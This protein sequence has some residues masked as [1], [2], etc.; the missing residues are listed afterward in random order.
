[1][2]ETENTETVKNDNETTPNSTPTDTA[3]T[4]TEHKVETPVETG[5]SSENTGT[6]N[7]YYSK[8]RE[9][10]TMNN[11]IIERDE[12]GNFDYSSC[13]TKVVE[14]GDSLFSIAQENHVPMQQ[15]RYFNNMPKGVKKLP[16]GKT[17][18][19]PSGIVDVPNGK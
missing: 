14:I 13:K 3:S 12:N 4:T 5:K 7:P 19:I 10:T 2:A 16:L 1:M 11:N 6:Y 18:Y 9:Q 15:L 8:E 17:V